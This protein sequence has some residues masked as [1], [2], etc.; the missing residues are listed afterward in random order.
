MA[1]S[2]EEIQ[3]MIS[4]AFPEAIVA[5]DAEVAQPWLQIRP[6]DLSG[7]CHFLRDT[8]GLYFDFLSCLSGVDYG[9]K[10]DAIGTVYHLFSIPYQHALVL[11][12][13]VKRSVAE[14]ELPVIPSVT[15][16]WKTADW[17]ERE[18][19]DLVGIHFEG[20]PDLR[21]ILMPADWEG[22][23]LRKDYEN[24]EFYHGIQTAY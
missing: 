23:P 24:P 14:N 15:S 4:A 3:S 12:C 5:A 2:F 7:L 13:T 19:Y 16:I 11:K 22:H 1:K 8:E 21:R 17:H 6:S 18:A 10:Q 20:H 9:P